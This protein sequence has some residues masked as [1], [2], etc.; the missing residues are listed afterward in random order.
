M[1][2]LYKIDKIGSHCPVIKATLL[3]DQW[4][5]SSVYRLLLKESSPKFICGSLLLFAKKDENLEVIG[6]F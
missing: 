3:E 5:L 4:T 2:M 1:Q 6:Q